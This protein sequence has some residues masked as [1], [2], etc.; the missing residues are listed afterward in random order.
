MLFAIFSFLALIVSFYLKIDL[1]VLSSGGG[2]TADL[3]THWN[4]I[5]ILNEDIKNLLTVELGVDYKI[6]SFPLHHLLISQMDFLALNQKIYLLYFFLFSF[7]VPLIFYFTI[8]KNY[9]NLKIND[10][11]T[12]VSLIVILPAYQYASI[13]GNPHISALFFLILS[14]Y[15]FKKLQ[16]DNFRNNKFAYL[17]I[18]FLALASYTRQYYVIFFPYFFLIFL[19]NC[20]FKNIF[21]IFLVTGILGVPG[22]L[23]V[24]INPALLLGLHSLNITNMNTSIII[25][26]SIIFFYL[27]PFLIQYF[28]NDKINFLNELKRNSFLTLGVFFLIIIAL[29]LNFY[30]DSNI[31]GGVFFKISNIIFN[32]NSLLLITAFLGI[33]F[34]FFYCTKNIEN[35]YLFLILG[36]TFT[37]GF[38]VF[39]KYF[40]PM[41]LIVFLIFFDK[42]KILKSISKNNYF[43]IFYYSSYY[44]LL[45]FFKFNNIF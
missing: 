18:F 27:L 39:Q 41:F 45:N 2:V 30:Y 37:S 24:K 34:T 44:L 35:L 17:T 15:F 5:L 38:F 32:N 22:L 19:K 28:F 7:F 26:Y 11:L 31:G 9:S 1:S 13:W 42:Q 3:N 12:L 14:F 21:K 16:L 4:Y 33:F 29:N 25:S 6:L 23:F 20:K 40:E 10:L 43:I 8:K 36:I